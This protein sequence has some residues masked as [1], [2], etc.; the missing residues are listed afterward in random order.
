MS[1]VGVRRQGEEDSGSE[2][3]EVSE[4]E[5]D[6]F[7][8]LDCVVA[9]LLKAVG[10]VAVESVEYIRFP[11]DEHLATGFEFRDFETVA[12]IQPMIQAF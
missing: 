2:G 4:A 7:Q 6:A 3:M 12:G 10:Q 5:G 11:V 8:S 1:N 9:A